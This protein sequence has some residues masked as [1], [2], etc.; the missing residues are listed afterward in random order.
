MFSL[1]KIFDSKNDKFKSDLINVVKMVVVFI[2][3]YIICS[4]ITKAL[5]IHFNLNPSG[6]LTNQITWGKVPISESINNIKN[7]IIN[8]LRFYWSYISSNGG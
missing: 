5:E 4:I 1:E 6:Y 3:S 7:Y 2:I 8:I